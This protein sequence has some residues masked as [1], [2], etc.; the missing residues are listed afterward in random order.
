M[1]IPA[2]PFG[3]DRGAI[4]SI[5]AG[6]RDYA[7]FLLDNRG[8]VLTWNSGA[9]AIKGYTADEVVGEHISL[10]Y[11]PED[12]AARRP[13]RLLRAAAEDGRVEDEGWRVRKDGTRFWADVVISAI[14]DASGSVIG[15]SK[16]TRCKL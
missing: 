11:T 13:E 8:R 12:V 6:V 7:I 3:A 14:T 5:L 10:F 4:E 9:Q 2:W 16:V 15:Y 1:D